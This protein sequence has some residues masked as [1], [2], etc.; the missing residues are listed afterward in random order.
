[1]TDDDTG[2]QYVWN[3]WRDPA[4]GGWLSEDP[5]RQSGG[6]NLYTYVN[7]QPT[8]AIDPTGL[9]QYT[10]VFSTF[11]DT[12]TFFGFTGDNRQPGQPGSSRFSEEAIVETDESISKSGLI[13]TAATPGVTRL[14]GTSWDVDPSGISMPIVKRTGPCSVKVDVNAYA[15]D[16][17]FHGAAPTVGHQGSVEFTNGGYDGSGTMT[18]Y[19]AFEVLINGGVAFGYVP[20]HFKLF[21]LGQAAVGTRTWTVHK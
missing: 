14:G 6:L 9:T 17:A 16:P 13:A 19:P 7:N 5:I 1:M 10:A 11:I 20:V 2:L 3:R 18:S 4:T 8:V 12:A 15:S 21:N